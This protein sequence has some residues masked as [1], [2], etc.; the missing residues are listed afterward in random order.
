MM[1]TRHLLRKIGPVERVLLVSA[2]IVFIAI[3]SLVCIS[4]A[5]PAGHSECGNE[6]Q[7]LIFCRGEMV[8]HKTI[9]SNA[10][11]IFLSFAIII[12]LSL[13][14]LVVQTFNIKLLRQTVG[15]PLFQKL[16]YEYT[17]LLSSPLKEMFS[18]GILNPQIYA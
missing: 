11:P 17:D 7:G 1:F 18:R 8:L 3:A 16:S 5:V 14:T 4:V 9:L 13:P 12:L 15:A 10:L 6:G 2:L